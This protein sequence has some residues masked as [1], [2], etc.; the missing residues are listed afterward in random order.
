MFFRRL[1]SDVLLKAIN[2]DDGTINW[3]RWLD[4]QQPT[5]ICN[6]GP[7]IALVSIDC[8]YILS[9][10]Y[11]RIIIP[12]AVYQEVTSSKDLTGVQQIAQESWI[13]KNMLR[14]LVFLTRAI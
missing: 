5:R 7:L 2:F 4:R 8:L 12:N 14:V 6:S 11:Q 1:I 9:R 10:F 3:N 13:E